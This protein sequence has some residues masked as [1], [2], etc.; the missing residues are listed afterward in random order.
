MKISTILL[1]G[2]FAILS[3]AVLAQSNSSEKTQK[4]MTG[5]PAASSANPNPDTT[6]MAPNRTWGPASTLAGRMKMATKDATR[7]RKAICP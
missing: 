6:G 7:C 2:A 1:A 3:T 5:D 4:S